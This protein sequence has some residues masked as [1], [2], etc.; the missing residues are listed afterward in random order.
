MQHRDEPFSPYSLGD[1]LALCREVDVPH[2]PAVQITAI[3]RD[4]W[5]KFDQDG[6]HQQRLAD[7]FA[8]ID[9]SAINVLFAPHALHFMHRWDTVSDS[10]LKSWMSRGDEKRTTDSAWAPALL[11]LTLDDPR[12]FD[13]LAEVSRV[14]V[15]VWRRPW[16][17]AVMDA[18]YPI[19]YRVFVNAGRIAG[20]SSYYPQ[21]PLAD[22]PAR[23]HEIG[24]ARDMTQRLIDALQ[25]RTPFEWPLRYVMPKNFT[26]DRPPD[27]GVAFTAD[28]L[29]R[30]DDGEVVF[31]EGG[32]PYGRGA[33]PCCFKEGDISGVALA[34]RNPDEA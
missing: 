33:H 13:V 18:G 15:P 11:G 1:W 2:I 34:D 32:P 10:W 4:D 16:V 3:E 17:E 12:A 21:R 19:E 28:F 6:P 30:A 27:L 26:L 22:S 31:I 24:Q 14:V 25:D 29:V 8:A 23:Q 20:I 7:V 9:R 5:R